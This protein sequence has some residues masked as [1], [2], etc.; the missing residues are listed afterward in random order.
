[1]VWG[2]IINEQW[3]EKGVGSPNK[4]WVLQE[5][6]K[7][8]TDEGGEEEINGCVDRPDGWISWL[9]DALPIQLHLN[10]NRNFVQF[11][12]ILLWNERWRHGAALTSYDHTLVRIF[13]VPFS[14]LYLS[15]ACTL[16]NWSFKS[17]LQFFWFSQHL[18][19]APTCLL[20]QLLYF[21]MFI[22]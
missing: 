22:R 18:K 21:K 2:I 20:R 8:G 11:L 1:M 14:P 4:L 5:G 6:W 10:F 3:T 13:F 19:Y 17:R 7:T 9:M 16:V 12:F 15:T